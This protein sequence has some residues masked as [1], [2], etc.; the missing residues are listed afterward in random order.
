MPP[1]TA[2]SCPLARCSR[3]FTVAA[4]IASAA[5]VSSML[6]CSTTRIMNTTRNGVGSV[7]T[8]CSSTRRIS[9]RAAACSGPTGGAMVAEPGWSTGSRSTIG[10]SS[11]VGRCRSARR[12]ASLI[13]DAGEPGAEA[14]LATVR[15]GRGEGT[16]PGVLHSF[17]GLAVIPQDASRNAP[18]RAVVALLHEGR[19]VAVA[20]SQRV[21]QRNIVRMNPVRHGPL[22]V[23]PWRSCGLDL[24]GGEKVPNFRRATPRVRAGSVGGCSGSRAFHGTATNCA[25]IAPPDNFRSIDR[26]YQSVSTRP[27][28]AA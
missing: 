9:A 27:S 8:A 25:M 15:M 10:A 21:Q 2:R 19:R 5:A 12:D 23:N 14:R 24:D 28:A 1:R 16:Q 13:R 7:S 4:G 20:A 26:W 22:R 17:L 18:E 3:V 6:N 11:T